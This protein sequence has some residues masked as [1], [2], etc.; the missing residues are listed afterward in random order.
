MNIKENGAVGLWVCTSCYN[1]LNSGENKD[2]NN[3]PKFSIAN[4][5]AIVDLPPQ[6]RDV[7]ITES[8]LTS[9]AYF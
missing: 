4:G 8:G 3:P 5:F 9:L 2:E 1:F 7:T 6:V